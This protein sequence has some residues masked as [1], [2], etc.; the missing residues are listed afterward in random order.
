MI[1]HK[2]RRRNRKRQSGNAMVE[3]A[4]GSSILISIFTGTFQY[5]YGFYVYNNL[6]TAVNNGAKYAA[7]RPY[8]PT[9]NTPEPCFK[10]A[11]QDMVAYGDPTGTTTKSVAPS[12]APGNVGL[13][14]TFTNGVPTA[15]TVY[16]S[17]YTIHAA[18][19]N[20]VLTNKPSV[21][22][23][24]LGRFAEGDGETCSQ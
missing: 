9:T 5:G 22:Y 13:T 2:T 23:P 11:V 6:Q 24:Y 14:V 18:V 21:T 16:I 7:L 20:I 10:T 8:E 1:M 4:L 19:A 12:L 15:M 17:S 3:F